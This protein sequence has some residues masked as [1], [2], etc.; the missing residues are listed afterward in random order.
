MSGFSDLVAHVETN[1][2]LDTDYF[3]ESVR[4]VTAEGDNYDDVTIH[5]NYST[6]EMDGVTVET[7]RVS[8]LQSALDRRPVAQDRLYRAGEDRAFLYAQDGT[9][10]PGRYRAVFQRRTRTTQGTK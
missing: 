3:A 6:R 9:D 7:L 5:A 10:S 8:F 1:V 4:Y 2:F